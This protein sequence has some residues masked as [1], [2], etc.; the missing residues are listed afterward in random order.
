MECRSGASLRLGTREPDYLAP[1][2]DFVLDELSEIGG[3]T[4]NYIAGQVSEARLYPGISETRVNLLVELVDNFARRALGRG[5]AV[6]G[7]G[8]IP[9][10]ELPHR[11]QIRQRLRARR[12]GYRQRA[13]RAGSNMLHRARQN[14]EHD[15]YLTTDHVGERRRRAAIGHVNEIDAGHHL[16]KLAGNMDRRSCTARRHIDLARI[17]LGIGDELGNGFGWNRWIY[18]H[19]ERHADDAG[20]RRD[21]GHEIEIQV[22]IERY[23]DSVARSDQ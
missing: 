19:D 8:L 20:D 9:W 6:P 23:I 3:R 22:F 4:R 2:L 10:Q 18:L 21:V 16:E 15:V 14:I 5:D 11:R 17:S 7:G 1:F 13:Q 12:A